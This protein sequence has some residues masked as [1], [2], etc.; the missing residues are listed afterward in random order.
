VARQAACHIAAYVLPRTKLS[1]QPPWTPWHG[2]EIPG[3]LFYSFDEARRLARAEKLE[4]SLNHFDEA[5][6]RDPLNPYIR[7]ERAAVYDQL[8]LWIDALAS[9]VDAVTI[10]SWFDRR[11][12]E[13]YGR[14][15]RDERRG[16][17]SRS[18]RSPNGTAALLVARY[19]AVCSLAA[20]QRLAKQWAENT[21]QQTI[22]P[23]R[24][25]ETAL[26]IDRLRPLVVSY[27]RLMMEA[28]NVDE[29]TRDVVERSIE[30]NDPDTLRRVFQFAALAEAAAIRD[31]YL[32]RGHRRRLSKRLAI[33]K[34]AMRVLPIWAALQYHYVELVQALAGGPINFKNRLGPWMTGSSKGPGGHQGQNIRWLDEIDEK[35]G[36]RADEAKLLDWPP[37][38]DGVSDWLDNTLSLPKKMAAKFGWGGVVHGWQA[39]YNTACAFAAGM[40]TEELRS[41]GQKTGDEVEKR[42]NRLVR[43]AINELSRA[44]VATDSQFAAGRSVWLRQGDQDFDQLRSTD[45]YK[46]FVERYLPHAQPASTVPPNPTPIAIRD[47]ITRMVTDY[48][49]SR[50]SFWRQQ[51]KENALD[52]SEFATESGWWHSLRDV[53]ENYWD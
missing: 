2:I 47:H 49:R 43:L 28:H 9:Y 29:S 3:E 14:I 20:A 36:L 21:S 24:R 51:A 11:A 45:P 8:G 16:G 34:E 48:A 5:I 32:R 13:R 44:V 38:P 6:R 35:V 50:E 10:E 33:T 40:M 4:E 1:L 52:A 39:H 7:V 41:L 27:A 31:D 37:D 26:V 15:V 17:P 53:C 23:K 18:S 19:R 22:Q 46:A 12:W 42:N 30:E 25:A